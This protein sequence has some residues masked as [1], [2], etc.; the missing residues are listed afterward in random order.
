MTTESRITSAGTLYVNGSFDEVSYN[1]VTL[2][3]NLYQYSQDFSQSS[4]WYPFRVTVT[5]NYATAPD[6]TNTATLITATGDYANM[7]VVPNANTSVFNVTPGEYWTTSIYVKYVDQ[8]YVTI[9]NEVTGGVS[10]L[11]V[12]DIIN[13]TIF[14]QAYNCT[15][16]TITSVGSGWWRIVSTTLIPSGGTG[17]NP[18]PIW[19]GNYGGGQTGTSALYWGAQMQ[20]SSSA[21]FYTKTTTANL[22]NLATY[23]QDGTQWS[24]TP[25][26]T[27]ISTT[28][29]APNGTYTAVRVRPTAQYGG[30]R[31]A[32]ANWLKNIALTGSA[33]VKVDSGTEAMQFG[34][35]GGGLSVNFTA[36]SSWQRYSTGAYTNSVAYDDSLYV[37]NFNTSSFVD[38]IVWGFQVEIGSTTTQY[39]SIGPSY[40]ILNAP[41]SERVTNTGICYSGRNFDEVTYAATTSLA[42]RTTNDGIVYVS[43]LFDE[44][45]WNP[46][47]VTSGLAVNLDSYNPNSYS[48][49]GTVWTD[50]TANQLQ[51]TM[52][53]G[54]AGSPFPLWT[55]SQQSFYTNASL[56]NGSFYIGANSVLDST[57]IT[58]EF[59]T[60]QVNYNAG[61][62]Y[63]NLLSYRESYGSVGYRMGVTGSGYP[64]FW[65]SQTGGN[66]SLQSSIA[67]SV[68]TWYQTAVTYDLAS[69]TCKIY[70]NGVLAGT[71]TSAVY[72]PPTGQQLSI[73]A[74]SDG[75][76]SMNGY[77]SVFRQYN[78]ALTA[79]QVQQNYNAT[80]GRYGY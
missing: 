2:S 31:T 1:P 18:H 48:G 5:P 23:S 12:F 4:Y 43:G 19:V 37:F 63:G 69:S 70:I 29:L 77:Y 67:T 14:N 76:T 6:G 39:Q 49:T 55:L 10:S 53:G 26:A 79:A 58:L 8:Q 75:I 34:L 24:T 59:W 40:T 64:V 66:F 20:K 57:S 9:V 21:T 11:A 46:P 62:E 74:V 38:F 65:T 52:S 25:Y 68:N 28:E 35:N 15:N 42:Q 16:A 33:W 54:T 72:N 45:T 50:L 41:F 36:T 17:W 73:Q 47:I 80:K 71:Q 61:N 13:G 22:I 60:Q 27:I 7:A 3:S 51:A 56:G 44:V 78:T 32:N 30:V